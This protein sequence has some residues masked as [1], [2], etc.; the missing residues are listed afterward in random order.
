MYKSWTIPY[1]EILVFENLFKINTKERL[2]EPKQMFLLRYEMQLC[3]KYFFKNLQN[4]CICNT[5]ILY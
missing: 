5:Y 4:L 3:S 2:A 1:T